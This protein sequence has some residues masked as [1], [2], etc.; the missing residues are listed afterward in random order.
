MDNLLSG[1]EQRFCVRHLYSNLRKKCAGK[2]IKDLMWKAAKS[3]YPQAWEKTMK[4]LRA[5][6]E[7]AFGKTGCYSKDVCQQVTFMSD[8]QKRFCVRHLY[9]NLRKKCAGKVIKDLMWKAAKSSYPQAW[10]KT[11]KELRA[12]SEEACNTPFSQHKNFITFI[13]VFNT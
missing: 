13:R 5:V 7:E 2:V 11:M 3:S 8:Q 10:E 4:E 1:V 12:V 6:S 9:S